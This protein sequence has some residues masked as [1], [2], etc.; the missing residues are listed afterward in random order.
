MSAIHP[1]QL[2]VHVV[3][4]GVS[5]AGTYQL[6]EG[7]VIVTFERKTMAV[8]IG[9]GLPTTRAVHL[10]GLLVQRAKRRG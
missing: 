10:L 8:E 7:K 6:E 1:F 9:V 2:P 3:I 4:G 5:Y